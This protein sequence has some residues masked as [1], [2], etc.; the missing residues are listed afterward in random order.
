[1]LTLILAHR[2]DVHARWIADQLRARLHDAALIAVESLVHGTRWDH[3]LDRLGAR[4]GLVLGDGREL[5]QEDVLGVVNRIALIPPEL[6]GRANAEDRL[7]AL[8]EWTAL[9]MSWLRSIP[10]PVLNRPDARG[11]CGAWRSPAEWAALAISVGLPT[12]RVTL[13][14]SQEM[15]AFMPLPAGSLPLAS[16]IVAGRGAVWIPRSRRAG[17]GPCALP[18]TA[19]GDRP[20]EESAPGAPVDSTGSPA[21]PVLRG[22]L[23]DC[24]RIAPALGECAMKLASRAGCELLGLDFAVAPGG[25]VVLSGV[26]PMPDLRAGGAP[27]VDAIESR[28]SGRGALRPAPA[29]GTTAPRARAEALSR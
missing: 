22:S 8:Q 17:V 1:M 21:A 7:Y 3:R 28:L 5:R 6:V 2:H 12:H 9:F 29:A 13:G 26:T 23:G 20:A 15:T 27:L 10:A 14:S 19:P 24:R 4:S 25:G 16:I 18:S 11:L